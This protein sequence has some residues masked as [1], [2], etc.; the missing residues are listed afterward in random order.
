MTDGNKS[1]MDLQQS[2]NNLTVWN[3]YKYYQLK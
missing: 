1:D 2:E 3:I